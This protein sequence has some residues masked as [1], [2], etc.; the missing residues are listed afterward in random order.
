[1]N[2]NKETY[3][4]TTLNITRFDAEDIIVTSG[5]TP[6]TP[7]TPPTFTGGDYE[8]VYIPGGM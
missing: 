3:E 4:R 1:M 6:P 8:G 2:M 5:E 7:P